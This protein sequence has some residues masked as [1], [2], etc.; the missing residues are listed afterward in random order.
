MTM[1]LSSDKHQRKGAGG[2]K[3]GEMEEAPVYPRRFELEIPGVF[4]ADFRVGGLTLSY[5]NARLDGRPHALFLRI[6]DDN[7]RVDTPLMYS[8][9][10]ALR[11]W[12]SNATHMPAGERRI[13]VIARDEQGRE[14]RSRTV[15]ARGDSTLYRRGGIEVEQEGRAG[16]PESTLEALADALAPMNRIL[17][18]R[19]TSISIYDAPDSTTAWFGVYQVRLDS[20]LLAIG[21]SAGRVAVAHESAHGFARDLEAHDPQYWGRLTGIFRRLRGTAAVF[22]ESGYVRGAPQSMGH[23]HSSPDELFASASAVLRLFPNELMEM[24]GRLPANERALAMETA[25]HVA[26]GYLAQPNLPQGFFDARLLEFLGIGL[27]ETIKRG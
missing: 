2:C 20:G 27:R 23:P 9:R 3:V 22:D 17:R 16:F 6:E 7:G 18:R 1:I 12:P 26:Q 5:E 14:R 8:D 10:G 19:M 21:E 11:H 13:T 24:M 4:R 15:V 25:R